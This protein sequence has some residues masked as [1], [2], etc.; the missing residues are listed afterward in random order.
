MGGRPA[1]GFRLKQAEGPL[2]DVVLPQDRVITVANGPGD[3]IRQWPILFQGHLEFPEIG[4]DEV[5]L[6]VRT[7][8]EA[9]RRRKGDFEQVAI[10]IDAL[11]GTADDL[12]EE[13]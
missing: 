6:F 11:P 9:R 3:L 8:R 12:E 7:H 1:T 10:G 13:N 5:E 4:Q 2:P